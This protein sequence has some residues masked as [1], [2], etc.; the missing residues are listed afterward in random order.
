MPPKA[1]ETLPPVC[2]CSGH[3]T[4]TVLAEH[5]V[6][7]F[8][9]LPKAR[10]LAALVEAHRRCESMGLPYFDL[11]RTVELMTRQNL[12]LQGRFDGPV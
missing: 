10:V 8:R 4:I 1:P 9:Y 2:C 6:A 5:L 11:L 7:D 12:T 3:P